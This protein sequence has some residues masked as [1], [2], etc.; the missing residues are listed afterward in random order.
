LFY[1]EGFKMQWALCW[2]CPLLTITDDDVT[3]KI[4]F[5]GI[6]WH[7]LR[8]I[9]TNTVIQQHCNL[10]S[11]TTHNPL[12]KW[13]QTSQTELQDDPIIVL[14]QRSRNE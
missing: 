5:C 9:K 10:L 4:T 2:I 7:D 13:L 3:T 6:S 14:G 12:R 1:F 8:S 11:F